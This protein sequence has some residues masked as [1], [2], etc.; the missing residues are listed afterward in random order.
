MKCMYLGQP[1]SLL[2]HLDRERGRSGVLVWLSF[3]SFFFFQIQ[4]Q[5][6]R[7]ADAFVAQR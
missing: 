4:I 2:D 1:S 5:S 3:F 7:K 6:L